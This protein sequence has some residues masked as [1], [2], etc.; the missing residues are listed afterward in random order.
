MKN[1]EA[2]S[3]ENEFIHFIAAK[4]STKYDHVSVEIQG[5]SVQY[6]YQHWYDRKDITKLKIGRIKEINIS[7]SELSECRL[8][9]TMPFKIQEL[10]K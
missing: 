2:L 6:K 3:L 9:K 4:L 1:I 8:N 7:K 5:N 10:L